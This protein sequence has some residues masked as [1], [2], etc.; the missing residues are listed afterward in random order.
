[1]RK[2]RPELGIVL[3]AIALAV[4]LAPQCGVL[5]HA[6][7]RALR[8]LIGGTGVVL[9]ATTVFVLGV[10]CLTPP[11][12]IRALIRKLHTRKQAP[13]LR[14]TP[15]ARVLPLRPEND[16]VRAGLKHL[17][18]DKSEIDSA[19]ARLDRSRST[20]LQLREALKLLRKAS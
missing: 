9:L 11:G 19:L 12:A 2:H 7:T 20:E 14:A 6:A 1:M 3:L 4:V 18:Y 13:R 8:T 10:M 5:G 15:P 16:E 17:G